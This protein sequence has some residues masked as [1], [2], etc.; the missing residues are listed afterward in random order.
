M[1]PNEDIARVYDR[2]P[3]AVEIFNLASKRVYY[4]FHFT[5]AIIYTK[6]SLDESGGIRK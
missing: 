1:E 6:R 3:M 5:Q 4:Q 2:Y